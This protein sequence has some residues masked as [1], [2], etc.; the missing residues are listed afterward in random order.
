M[1][2]TYRDRLRLEGAWLAACGV[3][4]SAVLLATTEE[5]RR[6]PLNTIGQLAVAGGL[7][8]ALGRRGAI[9]STD[10]AEERDPD[11]VGSGE[12]TPLWMHPLIV[13]GLA[14]LVSLPREFG[15]PGAG[16]DAGLRVTA[17]C[18]LVGL[19]QAF[20]IER[21]VA[22]AEAAKGRTYYRAKGSRGAKTVLAAVKTDA[23]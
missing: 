15:A 8:V 14:G 5:A 1:P 18:V 17:G 7:A 19:T 11:A 13:A 9:K 23:S 16:W 10:N 20:V 3:A 6:W 4:G 2:P 22:A 12:P 21:T